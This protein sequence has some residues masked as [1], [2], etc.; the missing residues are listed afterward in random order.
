[1]GRK[2]ESQSDV[3]PKEFER[4][5]RN[6]EDV[7]KK[8][9]EYRN[10]INL[11][12]EETINSENE[13]KTLIPKKNKLEIEIQSLK[14]QVPMIQEQIKNQVI[15][16]KES[17]LDQ[18]KLKELDKVRSVKKF[19]KKISSFFA[20]IRHDLQMKF[21]QA[22]IANEKDYEKA[23][24][25]ADVIESQVNKL[26]SEIIAKTK[27]R[28]E[29]AQKKLDDVTQKLEKLRK[30]KTSLK[31]AIT[32]GERNLKKMQD[33]IVRM[34]QEIEESAE[35]IK[36]SAAELKEN[37]IKAQKTLEEFQSCEEELQ[38]RRIKSYVS[39]YYY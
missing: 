23:K 37:E 39:K 3:N 5:E 29:S 17:T 18:K 36:K 19:I 10:R 1:M 24:G 31:V 7:N 25:E 11:L 14:S 30:E 26:H 2:A 38:V 33:R 4:M 27:G 15:K 34:K 9:S 16:C 6:L 13:L 35:K 21:L 20:I 12:E 32:T 8:L 28:L 22:V